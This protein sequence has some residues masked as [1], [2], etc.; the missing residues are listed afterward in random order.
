MISI[1][2][3][4]NAFALR[5]GIQHPEPGVIY[6]LNPCVIMEGAAL[7]N[8]MTGEAVVV[9]DFK[10]DFQSLV[11]RWFYVPQNFDMKSMVYWIRQKTLKDTASIGRPSKNSYTIF[12]TTACNASCNYCFEKGMKI[13]TMSDETAEDVANY[14]IKTRNKKITI[15]IKWFGGEPLC[16]TKAIDIICKR[17]N[18]N[19]ISFKSNITTNGELFSK[20][21]DEQI[22]LWRLKNIQVTLDDIGENYGKWKGLDDKAY[23]R[24]RSQLERL[25]NL[26]VYISVRVHYHPSEG[27]QPCYRVVDALRDIKGLNMY[28]RIVYKTETKE[29]YEKILELEE[30]MYKCGKYRYTFP[31][32]GSG[33]HC[34]GDNQRI[35]CITPEGKLSPCEHYAYGEVYSSIYNYGIVNREML[36]EWKVKEKYICDC[37]DCKLYPLCEKLILCPAEGNCTK[38]Y[39][40]YQIETIKRALA[41]NLPDDVNHDIKGLTKEEL[42]RMC[43]VC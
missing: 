41:S 1:I 29:D 13:L 9:E 24:L 37:N 35:A 25:S 27:L 5:L 10:K 28:A 30:Y 34:M 17:L 6:V 43:G 19:G 42:S 7:Y 3:K 32:R 2:Q 38:G 40:Y 31:R 26:G 22:K 8:P 36:T 20:V 12:T 33:I 39:V 23:D 15:T 4:P 11:Q 21:T 16:N 14:I 18:E